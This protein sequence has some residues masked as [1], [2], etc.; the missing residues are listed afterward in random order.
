M[1]QVVRLNGNQETSSAF[2]SWAGLGNL[3]RRKHAQGIKESLLFFIFF[4][5]ASG[6]SPNIPSRVAS[7][8]AL[9]L[10]RGAMPQG[11]GGGSVERGV[12][13]FYSRNVCTGGRI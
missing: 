6:G 12:A 2:A 11:F 7:A 3:S 4:G 10:Q 8:V 9:P 1:L 13:A 5:K